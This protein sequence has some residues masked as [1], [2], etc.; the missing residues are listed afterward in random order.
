MIIVT[1]EK[2]IKEILISNLFKHFESEIRMNAV[3]KELIEAIKDTR[4][5]KEGIKL[6]M[7]I[8]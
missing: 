8:E 3:V 5:N 6:T 7:E 1:D 2:R 4:I